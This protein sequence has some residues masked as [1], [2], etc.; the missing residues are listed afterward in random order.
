MSVIYTSEELPMPW[1]RNAVQQDP[2]SA[3]KLSDKHISINS[4]RQQGRITFKDISC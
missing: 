3:D 1:S 2:T 4:W